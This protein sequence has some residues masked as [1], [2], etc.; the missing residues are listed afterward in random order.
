MEEE[1]ADIKPKKMVK[2]TI[3]FIAVA[4]VLFSVT[5]VWRMQKPSQ[6]I[7]KQGPA[8]TS[9]AA[10]QSKEKIRL[11]GKYLSFAYP[12]SYASAEKPED[13]VAQDQKTQEAKPDSFKQ[14]A[15]LT[16]Y[17]ATSSKKIA[18]SVEAV[19]S[20]ILEDNTSFKFRVSSPKLYTQSMA[21]VNGEKI[22][23]FTRSEDIHEQSFFM[24][25]NG[26]VASI[27]LSSANADLESMKEELT[28][29]AASVE[30]K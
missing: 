10:T 17:T 14:S 22:I 1:I 11:D 13:A 6:G 4:A 24:K 29:V 23:L 18:V 21:E 19:K 26:L 15:F 12:S 2:K 7:V 27:V 8:Q 25:H 16:S 28:A 5:M 3:L 9:S 20:G 30:W